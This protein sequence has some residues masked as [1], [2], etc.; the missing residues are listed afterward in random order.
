MVHQRI[1]YGALLIAAIA[2]IGWGDVILSNRVPVA[3]QLDLRYGSLIPLAVLLIAWAGALECLGLCRKFGARPVSWA[4]LGGIGVLCGA[5]CLAPLSPR[6][7]PLGTAEARSA[8]LGIAATVICGGQVFRRTAE[9]GLLNMA[10]SIFI[11]IYM[12]LLPSFI[13]DLRGAWAGSGGVWTIVL[14]V[15]TVKCT[16]IGA[17]FTGLTLGRTKLIPLISPGKTIEGLCGGMVAAAAIAMILA[18]TLPLPGEISPWAAGL[19][20]AVM[21]L[22]GQTGDLVESILKREAGAKDSSQLIP[23]FGGVL[24]LLDSPVFAAPVAT[25]LLQAWLD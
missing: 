16:D 17:Y 18:R 23:T 20:G 13:I 25:I 3:D 21:A 9:G 6:L 2:G 14:F 1:F 5:A 12:G 24:D 7:A 22:V 19:F 8:I 15:A 4:V 10:T 11:L